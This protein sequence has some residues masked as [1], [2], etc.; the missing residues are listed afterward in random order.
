MGGWRA[1]KQTNLYQPLLVRNGSNLELIYPRSL[2]AFNA[3]TGY[4]VE[5]S[6]TLAAG[7]WQI[8]GVTQ[9]LLSTVAT[10][11]PCGP[12]S[13]QALSGANCACA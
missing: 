1:P 4:A 5:W 2:A 6:G 3:R 9:S 10:C 13:P 7:S 12:P 11:R 8:T